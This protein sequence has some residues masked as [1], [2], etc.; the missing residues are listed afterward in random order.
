MQRCC[1]VKNRALACHNCMTL[2]KATVGS[3]ALQECKNGLTRAKVNFA[4]STV[5][6]EHAYAPSIS[7]LRSPQVQ[8]PCCGCEL[9]WVSHL[10]PF[11]VIPTVYNLDAGIIGCQCL[12]SAARAATR[13]LQDHIL[14][15]DCV[16]AIFVLCMCVRSHSGTN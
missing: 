4:I 8:A 9:G 3:T 5:R 7:S 14:L 15:S 10:D 16:R 1:A 11:I 13:C 2:L 6:G 12:S